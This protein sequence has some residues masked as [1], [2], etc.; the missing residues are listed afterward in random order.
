MELYIVLALLVL[1]YVAGTYR[2][3]RHYRSILR[4]EQ[5]L[6]NVPVSSMKTVPFDEDRIERAELIQGS[7]VVGTDYFKRIAASLRNLFGGN[8]RVYESLIDR[9]RR[10]AVLRLKE[11]AGDADIVVCLRIET[12][13]IGAGS[14]N[15]YA[16]VEAF[17]YGTAITLKGQCA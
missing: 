12:S 1:G 17:A 8:I 3:R 11:S 15:K 16:C 10:E 5:E 2:E 7:V 4:R 6:V 13:T 14:K 9:A